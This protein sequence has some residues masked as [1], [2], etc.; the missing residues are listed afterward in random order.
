MMRRALCDAK[1]ETMSNVTDPMML[2]ATGDEIAEALLE[3]AGQ[4]DT[5]SY[6]SIVAAIRRGDA[7]KIPNG[8]S[9]AVPHAVYGNI[10]FV[11]RRKNVDKVA[12]DPER[13]TIT[14]QP[15]YLLSVNGGSSAATFQYDRP[16]SICAALTEEIPANTVVKFTATAYDKWAAGTYHFTATAAIPVGSMLCLNGYAYQDGGL[17]ARKI[18]VFANAKATSASASYSI[19][20]GDGDAT[21]NLGTWGTDCNHVHRISYGSNNEAEANITQWLNGIGLMSNIWTPK[22]KYDMMC[23]SYTSLQGFLGGFPEDFRACL[24]LA[25]IHN[26]TNDVFESQDSAYA[27][28]TEY[29]HTGYFWLPSRKEIYGTNENTREDSEAQFEY[30]AQLGTTNADK[31][32]YAKGAASPTS[33]WLRT[34]FAGNANYVRICYTGNGGA[35]LH[36]NA[37][38]SYGVA[39]LAILA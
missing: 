23:T 21:V 9:F 15:K 34:P 35:L 31:L 17:T 29:Y 3:L 24:A 6:K 8:V 5:T 32:M 36:Y 27:K 18:Q 20:S 1:E 10:E 13:E 39:P 14:I 33:Y 16:E 7:A 11:V 22:T 4:Y 25:K 2:D 38:Y 28:S 37:N 26:I 30:Y 19:E 12:G